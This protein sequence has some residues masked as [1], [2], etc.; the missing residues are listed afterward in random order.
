MR[1]VKR[2]NSS[3]LPDDFSMERLVEILVR[4]GNY[5]LADVIHAVYQCR[6][7]GLFPEPEECA[8]KIFTMKEEL[9]N[10]VEERNTEIIHNSEVFAQSQSAIIQELAEYKLVVRNLK[11]KLK[12]NEHTIQQWKEYAR[13]LENKLKF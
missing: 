11:A 6:Y 13:E 5:E 12:E 9:Q 8:E 1:E 3:G 4:T 10:E 2:I 7:E